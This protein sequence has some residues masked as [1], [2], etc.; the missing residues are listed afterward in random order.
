[1]QPQNL[2][3]RSSCEWIGDA[4]E[5]H[6]SHL[7]GKP[8]G[9][10]RVPCNVHFSCAN[11]AVPRIVAGPM[12][13]RSTGS[14]APRGNKKKKTAEAGLQTPQQSKRQVLRRNPPERPSRTS[15]L[16]GRGFGLV[17]FF[18]HSAGGAQ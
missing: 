3:A 16:T 15:P 4:F 14:V 6:A 7:C 2:A 11:A 1:M 18:P 17:R 8:C 5:S 9:E 12:G 10:L 13:F